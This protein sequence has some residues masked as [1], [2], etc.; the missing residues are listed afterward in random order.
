MKKVYRLRSRL[1]FQAVYTKGRSVA[2][3]AAVLYMLSQKPK[4]RTK[5]GFAAGKKLGKAVV[6]NRIKRRIKE[7]VRVL[8]PRVKAGYSMVIIARRSAKDMEFKEL[9]ARVED[10]FERA[11]VLWMEGSKT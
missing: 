10:L 11:G 9:Q 8:W 7:A 3:K 6:R 2:N 4:G 5:I 1:E